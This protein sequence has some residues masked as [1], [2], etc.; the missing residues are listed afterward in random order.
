[1]WFFMRRRLRRYLLLF[2]A[3]PI[4]GRLMVALSGALEGRRGS[5]TASRQLRSA[6]DYLVRRSSPRRY[7]P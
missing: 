7:N 6:G 1:M 3:V 5:T 2:I 4:A